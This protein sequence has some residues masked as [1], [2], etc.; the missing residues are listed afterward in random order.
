MQ[1]L[2]NLAGS[3][4]TRL[5]NTALNFK[6]RRRGTDNRENCKRNRAYPR[7]S[8]LKRSSWLF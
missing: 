1:P 5:S 8:K 7:P 3:S 6:K 4:P 2:E